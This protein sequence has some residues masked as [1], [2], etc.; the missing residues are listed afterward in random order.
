MNYRRF[1]DSLGKCGRRALRGLEAELRDIVLALQS[2]T[3]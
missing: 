3:G 1:S 2:P